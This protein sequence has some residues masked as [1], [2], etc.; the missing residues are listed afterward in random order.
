MSSVVVIGAG[1]AAAKVVEALREGDFD[2]SITLVGAEDHP[3][4]ERPGLSKDYL[5]G[6][7]SAD[8]LRVHEPQWY[9]AHDIEMR[10]AD[11]ATANRSA[12]TAGD[13]GIGGETGIRL[14]RP[15]DRCAAAAA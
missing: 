11:P 10:Y 15:G 1:L 12:G 7:K 5:A 9:A 4:Y 13:P 6:T 14:A 2:G 3:P 8:T